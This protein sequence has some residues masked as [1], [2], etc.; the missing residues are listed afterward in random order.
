MQEVNMIYRAVARR[1]LSALMVITLLASSWVPEA[2]AEDD[3]DSRSRDQVNGT[4]RAPGGDESSVQ[5]PL[6][7]SLSGMAKAEYAAARVLYEDGD[8]Q[9]ALVKLE[10]AFK[11]SG[12][13]RLLWN[14][15]AAEKNLRHYARVM[16]LLDRYLD[17]GKEL[18]TDEDRASADQLIAT[19][20]SFVV[21]VSLS[22]EPEGATVLLDGEKLTTA[23]AADLV[24]VDMGGHELIVRKPGYVEH[25]EKLDLAGGQRVELKVALEPE[26][27][28]GTLRI[29]TNARAVIRVDGKVVGTGLYS[30]TL[31]S[32]THTV[33]ISEP[34]KLAHQTEV[35]V[36]DRDTSALHV[37]LQ[38][39]QR[40]MLVQPEKGSS[41][42]WWVAGGA[43]LA[44]ASVGAYFILRPAS[45]TDSPQTGTWGGFEL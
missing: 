14:M 42:W 12:D 21:D 3:A 38:E 17:E 31:P 37:T 32:G 39:E 30:G 15:A 43:V 33:H 4:A 29:V 45:E 28:E 36:K 40:P 6:G 35:V 25:R 44:G 10:S 23:P 18:V 13:P 19:V 5:A 1:S 20:R 11:L 41:A 26:V 7:E 24:R 34:G 27:H 22:I 2:K 8:Y 9:G 16:E